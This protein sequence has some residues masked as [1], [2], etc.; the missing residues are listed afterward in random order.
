EVLAGSEPYLPGTG[1]LGEMTLSV[2]KAVYLYNKG[3]DGI[4]D[5]SP[6][7]CMNGIVSEAVYP[8]VSA[9]HDEIPIRSLYF[10]KVGGHIDRDLEIFLDLAR[11]YQRRKRRPR[12]YPAYF[13]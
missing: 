13:A 5:I 10:D 1:A 4:I 11:A 2:G 12:V 6:F 8:A 3:A 9:E 7:T